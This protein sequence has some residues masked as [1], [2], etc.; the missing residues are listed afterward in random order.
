LCPS[1]EGGKLSR[2]RE[3]GFVAKLAKIDDWITSGAVRYRSL[4]SSTGAAAGIEIGLDYSKAPVPNHFYFAD[5]VSVDEDASEVMF[6]FGKLDKPHADRLRTK[7]EVYFNP[8][9]FVKQFWSQTRDLQGILT[10]Y[11]AEQGLKPLEPRGLLEAPKAQTFH[12]NNV[13]VIMTDGESMMDFFYLSPKD[14]LYKPQKGEKI[15]V[16]ALVRIL[17]SP[18]LLLLLLTES[19]P[20]ADKLLPKY[21]DKK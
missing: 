10:K 19:Q 17:L 4:A 3:W 21:G 14:L 5:Y 13:S 16:E 12:S 20:F 6:T 9:M 7:V 2:E 1:A 18:S 8:V 15:D 11:V